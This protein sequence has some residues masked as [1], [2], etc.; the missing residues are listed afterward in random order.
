MKAYKHIL[1]F[2]LVT[3]L[4]FSGL[5]LFQGED[6][7]RDSSVDLKDVILLVKN[8]SGTAENPAGFQESLKN[9][10]S[11]LQVT[12]GMKT[13]IKN[14]D[15]ANIG[16]SFAGLDFTFIKSVSVSATAV[17]TA[18]Y[19]TEI[20]ISYHSLTTPPASPPPKFS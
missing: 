5:P 10:V 19:L 17:E 8:F 4:L 13:V 11:A 7:S 1:S 3:A 12:A 6:A 18:Y 16:S 20:Q 2:T 14:S 15:E 9:M